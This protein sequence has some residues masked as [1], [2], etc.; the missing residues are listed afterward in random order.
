MLVARLAARHVSEH[1]VDRLEAALTNSE[2]A[3]GS[4]D[5]R[6]IAGT[7]PAFHE[8]MLEIT[9]STLLQSLMRLVSGRVRCADP[10]RR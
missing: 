2:A 4:G 9:E 10:D 7:N 8:V 6:A 5:E 1:G 3:Y